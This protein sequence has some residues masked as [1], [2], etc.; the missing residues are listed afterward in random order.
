MAHDDE[1]LFY[2]ER[3]ELMGRGI[4]YVDAHLMAAVAPLDGNIRLWTRD[5]RLQTL[6]TVQGISYQPI[7][8]Q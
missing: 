2:I 4:G 1:V 7:Q 6:A 3:H 8:V 5:Q